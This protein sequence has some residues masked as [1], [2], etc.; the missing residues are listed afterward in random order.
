MHT[1]LFL[2]RRN[3]SAAALLLC[4]LVGA[5]TLHAQSDVDRFIDTA[6]RDTAAYARLARLVD[7][8]GSR[9]SGSDRLER[10]IDW[11]VAEMKRD[12]LENVHTEPVMVPHWE[13]GSEWAELLVPRRMRLAMLGL[14]RSIG[15]PSQGITAP[16]L[17]VGSFAELRARAAEA[18]GKIVLFD[19]PFRQDLPPFDAY[20]D[21]VRYRVS[22]ADSAASVGA[23]AVL[24]RSI[25]SFSMRSPHTGSMSYGT[26]R[27]IPAAALSVEDAEMLHRMQDRGERI[28]VRLTMGAR[29]LPPAPSRNV[30]AELR[31]SERPDEIV[32]LG[33]HIDSWDVGQG[34]MD[35]GGGS[36][37][38]WEVLRL[39]KALG[40]RPKRTVRVVL[41]TN[42]ES[43]LAGGRAYRDAHRAELDRHILALESDNGV[44]KPQGIRVTGSPATEAAMR[45]LVAPLERIGAATVTRGDPEADV[46]PIVALGVPGAALEIDGSRYFWY[47]HSEAD[48][49]DKLD[50][51]D[52]A[53]CVAVMGAVALGA[54]DMDGTLR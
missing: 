37:A 38:A 33:G 10:A 42:E 44:F 16:V 35:D 50:P 7:T 4:A 8:F 53:L 54:A 6:Q 40:I 47:H 24:V 25:A 28:V 17:V 27:R 11:I 12:G 46:S 51:H 21:A 5:R 23:V 1:H 9:P 19:Y 15:T 14:G 39:M 30:V 36:V 34:A 52:M 20:G 48:T 18:R 26:A 43:G 2:R 31:G 49:I 22:G 32:V 13:R 41:W 29:T 3:P 45:R